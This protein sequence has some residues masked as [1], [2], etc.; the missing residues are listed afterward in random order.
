MTIY[1]LLQLLRKAENKQI[2]MWEIEQLK[3]YTD[4][5][6][7]LILSS[8][9]K[10][11][12]KTLLKNTDFRSLPQ[13]IQKEILK[14]IGNFN[15]N[16]SAIYYAV[17]IAT[18]KNTIN[19]GYLKEIIEII[20]K[21]ESEDKIILVSNIVTNTIALQHKDILKMLQ[22]IVD[23]PLDKNILKY[24]EILIKNEFA[25]RTGN[26]LEKVQSILNVKTE[27]E[28][29]KIF[30]KQMTEGFTISLLEIL[31]KNIIDEI[32]F[33]TLLKE[34]YAMAIKLLYLEYLPK[35]T[36][37]KGLPEVFT[38]EKYD[39]LINKYFLE[40]IPVSNGIKNVEL[41][42]NIKVRRKQESNKR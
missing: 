4:E 2:D 35:E 19:S 24:A 28:A 8:N 21:L 20:I 41:P 36:L 3:Y 10:R 15:G 9:N 26:M 38:E 11:E 32:D 6:T 31:D 34:D 18:N 22:M 13:E 1:K 33:W 12:V 40:N 37:I 23:S 29:E 16:R 39:E 14:I 25:H 42:S 30:T 17:N 27:Q 7:E 5:E